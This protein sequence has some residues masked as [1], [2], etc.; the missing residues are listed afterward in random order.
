MPLIQL[1]NQVKK[2]LK[3]FFKFATEIVQFYNQTYLHQKIHEL[4]IN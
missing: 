2:K 3:F 1:L 4:Q